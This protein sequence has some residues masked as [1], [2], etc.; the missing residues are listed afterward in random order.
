[1]WGSGK[2]GEGAKKTLRRGINNPAS[3]GKK[4][5]VPFRGTSAAENT[6]KGSAEKDTRKA[7]EARENDT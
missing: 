6:K 2:G 3:G 7:W 4:E 5:A 1:M